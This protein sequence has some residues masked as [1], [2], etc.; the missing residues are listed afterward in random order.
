MG[1]LMSAAYILGDGHVRADHRQ[2][3]RHHRDVGRAGERARD[4]RRAR[5]RRQHDQGA[6][7]G[8]RGRLGRPGRLPAVPRLPRQ[9]E[10]AAWRFRS[11]PS[12]RSTSRRSTCSSAA[13]WASCWCSSSAR[14][15]SAPWATRPATIIEEVRR[16]FREDPGIMAG[17]SR[18]DYA[19]AVDITAKAALREMIAAGHA[20]RRHAGRGRADLPLRAQRQRSSLNGITYDHA[21]LARRLR[22]CSSSARSAASSWRPSSTTAAAPGTTRRSSS[23]PAG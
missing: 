21:R 13:C 22:A 4:H 6:H 2:R 8:L 20:R 3:R 1:M 19:A 15:P 5:R 7:Q 18:P 17:T 10:G 16:Q 23:S 9:G 11:P 14:W 12:C